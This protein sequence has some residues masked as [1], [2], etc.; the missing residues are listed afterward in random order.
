MSS[1]R[2]ER[3]S[4]LLKEVISGIILNEVNDPR[5][6]FVTLTRVEPSPDLTS[7]KVFVSVL[8]AEGVCRST[9]RAIE[10]AVPFIRRRVGAM[11]QLRVVPELHFVRDDSARRSVQISK[12][13]ADALEDSDVEKEPEDP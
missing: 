3:V 8:G 11:V 4:Q 5:M 10:A 12:L 9:M 2:V 6:G 7:A 1:R 13:I